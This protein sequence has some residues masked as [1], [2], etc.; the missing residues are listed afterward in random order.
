MVEAA[1]VS[2]FSTCASGTPNKTVPGSAS[3]VLHN[4]D[5]CVRSSSSTLA[6]KK[7]EV[8]ALA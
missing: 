4:V 3:L 6:S 8:V 2:V 1:T 7:L 5:D